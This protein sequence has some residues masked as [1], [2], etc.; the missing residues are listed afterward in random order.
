MP[1]LYKFLDCH[2]YK[3]DWEQFVKDG[4]DYYNLSRKEAENAQ[5]FGDEYTC[6]VPKDFQ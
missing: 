4:M 5:M 3:L 2:F 6:F 1:K